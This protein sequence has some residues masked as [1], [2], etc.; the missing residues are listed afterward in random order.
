[1][2]KISVI[3]PVYNAEM[4]LKKCLNS[5]VNQTY[6]NIEIIVVN[7]GSNDNSKNIIDEYKNRYEGIIKVFETKNFGVAIARNYGIEKVSGDYF[8]FVDADDYIELDLIEKLSQII[9]KEKIDIVKY[10]MK[11]INKNEEKLFDGPS[12]DKVDGQTAFN[13][14]CFTDKMI[15]TPCL[16]LFNTKFFKENSFMFLKESYHEDFG[17][18]PLVMINAKNFIS[19]NIYGYNYVQV[20]GSI[21]RDESYEKTL[22]KANDLFIHYDNMIKSIEKMQLKESTTKNILIYYTNA[23]LQRIKELNKEDKKEYAKKIKERELVNNLKRK[24][25]KSYIKFMYY[26]LIIK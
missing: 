9:E 12:F 26:K 4:Y 21:I 16:Y 5:I 23:I 6:K 22:K 24:N 17:L 8:L 14:L 11:L 25:I 3:V 20:T 2:L 15:D 1:M 19:S 13:K 10:K 7:D 18:I